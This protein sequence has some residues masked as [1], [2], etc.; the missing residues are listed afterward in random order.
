MKAYQFKITIKS[1]KPPVWRRFVVPA[2]ITFLQLHESLVEIMG[3]EEE[4]RFEF[5]FPDQNLKVL[6]DGKDESI[7]RSRWNG[8]DA[9]ITRIDWYTVRHQWFTYR[10]GGCWAHRIELEK[11]VSNYEE[12]YPQVIKA[13]GNCPPLSCD[14]PADYYRFLS[15]LANPLDEEYQ[16]V[17]QIALEESYGPYDKEWVNETLKRDMI[18]KDF[19]KE[20]NEKKQSKLVY[21]PNMEYGENSIFH[22]LNCYSM[23][24]LLKL[25]DFLKMKGYSQ[26]KKEELIELITSKTLDPEFA[27]KKFLFADDDE[28]HFFEGCM[29]IPKRAD[30]NG[31][32]ILFDMLMFG[33]CHINYKDEFVVPDEVSRLFREINTKEFQKART[34]LHL[35][36]DYFMAANHLYGITPISKLTEIINSQNEEKT[37]KKELIDTYYDTIEMGLD[38]KLVGENIIDKKIL[39]QQ[40]VQILMNSQDGK[41]YYIPHKSV[42]L[43]YKDPDFYEITDEMRELHEYLIKVLKVPE[44]T[45]LELCRSIYHQISI[46]SKLHHVM[47]QLDQAGISFETEDQIHQVNNMIMEIWNHTRMFTN[48]GYT[49]WE[50]SGKKK[51]PAGKQSGNIIPFPSKIKIYPNNPCPCGSGKKYKYCCGRK[52]KKE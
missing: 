5:E 44:K 49:A 1:T 35:I 51:K 14:G 4:N 42:F 2:E 45:T 38:F 37:S 11:T 25:A 8:K 48:R 23:G 3:W 15:I 19:K 7:P 22:I 33:Y 50:L 21:N 20:I 34:R 46:G 28:I 16:K 52:G 29:N 40:K 31:I 39:E 13:V 47:E 26:L 30:E 27:S 43:K 6:P 18:L 36:L 10:L 17:K 41:P 24:D 12:P 32:L 9:S